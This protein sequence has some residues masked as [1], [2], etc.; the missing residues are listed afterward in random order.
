MR[1]AMR[2]AHLLGAK[3]P[4]MHRLVPELVTQMGQAF[5]EL[6]QAQAL[7]EDS[8]LNEETRFRQTLDRGLKL[9]DTAM[10]D[11]PRRRRFA[12]VRQ[13]SSSMTPL[14]FHLI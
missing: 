14:D 10:N 6:G 9:L 2:H 12:G 3:D 8:L 13:R 1:R 4:V 5:P 11:I 7:I